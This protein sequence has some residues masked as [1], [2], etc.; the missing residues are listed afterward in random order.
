M[1]SAKARSPVGTDLSSARSAPVSA[2]VLLLTVLVAALAGLVNQL[3]ADDGKSTV[4]DFGTT[5]LTIFSAD[6]KHVLGHA[7]YIIRQ[8]Y[9]AELLRGESKYSDGEHDIEIGRF[10]PNPGGEAPGLV[11]YEHSFYSADQ[12][13]QRAMSLDVESGSASCKS[14]VHGKLD[15][16]QSYLHVPAD[17]Y[18]GASQLMFV[19]IRLRQGARHIQFHSFSCMPGPRIVAV[20]AVLETS[21]VKWPMYPGELA[22]LELQPNFGWLDP[23]IDPFIPKMYAWFD[24]DDRWNYVG[25]VYD[26]F[27]GGPHIM[28]VRTNRSLQAKQ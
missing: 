15:E 25:G 21:R 24:P 23:L 7:Q 20:E 17:T 3:A 1:K 10:K 26:R 18:A 19:M 13:P 22:R 12:S 4:A 6:G 28:T 2:V 5:D 9:G 16:R 11:S 14:Y 8:S 27:Y